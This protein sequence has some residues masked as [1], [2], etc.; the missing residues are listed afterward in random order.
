MGMCL[1]CLSRAPEDV[2]QTPDPEIRRKQLA[3]AAEKRQKEVTNRGIKNPEA[4]ERKKKK[5]EEME[6]H[7]LTS[8]KSGEGG[9]LKVNQAWLECTLQGDNQSCKEVQFTQL[10]HELV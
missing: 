7:A 5:L 4:V 6:K 1:P 9:G 8:S 2:V 10:Y 3:E